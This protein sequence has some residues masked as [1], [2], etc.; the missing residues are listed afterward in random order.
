MKTHTNDTNQVNKSAR[1]VIIAGGGLAGLTAAKR[2]LEAGFTVELYEGRQLLGGKVSAWRDAEGDWVESGLHVFF[3]A[4]VEIYDL[5][6]ELGVYE[7]ILWKEHVLTYTLD[8]GKQFEFRTAPLPSPLHLMPAVFQNRYFSLWEKLSLARALRPMLF[9][10]EDYFREQDVKS[11]SQWH[12]EFGISDRMLKKMFLPMALAL[13]FLPPQD[14]SAKIVLDVSGTF[15][16]E[17]Q[18]SRMGFLSGSPAEKLTGPLTAD[19]EKR[20]GVIYR[21]SPIKQ[22]IYQNGQITGIEL[23]NGEIVHADYYLL[24]L[25]IHKLQQVLPQQLRD[26]TFFANLDHFEGVPVITAQLWFD[27]QVTQVNNILF[28]PDGIIPVYADLGNTTPD[29]AC[30]GRSR[31]EAVVAP[32]RELWNLTDAEIVAQVAANLSAY[33][34]AAGRAAKV[35]KSTVVRIPRSVYW[36]KP[37][38]DK[39]RPTQ[40]TPIANLF[41]AGGYTQQRF[42]DSM[43]GA[44]SSGNR[45]AKALIAQAT[46]AH[47]AKAAKAK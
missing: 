43:E 1:R 18:A 12:H 39:F 4:Y 8:Q 26:Y 30:Q 25:P 27:R 22:L 14:L 44:V 24:A 28:S 19:I 33:F 13:K 10:S 17:P 42:Y 23:V 29:Y 31:V 38:V 21:Q 6:R 41:L 40:T 15:L 45:A 2:L 16:R 20:G 9:G 36:P 11:Y 34:P 47:Q 35:V 46:T 5:M 3:G 32:A 7:E 37:G